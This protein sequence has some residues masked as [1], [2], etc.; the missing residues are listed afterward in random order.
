MD[1]N[2]RKRLEKIEEQIA[3]VY[4]A[5]EKYL[6]LDAAREHNLAKIIATVQGNSQAAKDCAAKATKEWFEFRSALAIAEAEFHKQKHILEL[7]NNAFQ[8]EYL[9]LKVEMPTISKQGRVS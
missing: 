9:S 3:A 4:A 6:T 1:S 5:E 2:L 7:K 8:A